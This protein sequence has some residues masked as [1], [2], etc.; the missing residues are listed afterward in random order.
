[1]ILFPVGDK[2][3]LMCQCIF[4]SLVFA[5]KSLKI[6]VLFLRTLF[7]PRNSALQRRLKQIFSCA[8]YICIMF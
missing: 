7:L 4:L 8:K 2:D 3:I 1:M 5:S 6:L